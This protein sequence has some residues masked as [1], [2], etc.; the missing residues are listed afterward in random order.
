MR[1]TLILSLITLVPLS[2][3]AQTI[4]SG[5]SG[6]QQIVWTA[7]DLTAKPSAFSYRTTANKGFEAYQK[8]IQDAGLRGCS[9]EQ[10]VTLVSVVGSILSFREDRMTMCPGAAHPGNAYRFTSIDLSRQGDIGYMESGEDVPI[11]DAEKPGL[12][13]SLDS[14]FPADAI[15]RALS[16]DS[17]LKSQLSDRPASLKELGE[18][19]QGTE[20][21]VPNNPCTFTLPED[22][23]TRFAFHHLE[24]GQVAV[25]IFLEPLAGACHGAEAQLGILLPISQAM[26][27]PLN[28]AARGTE[29]FLVS[30]TKKPSARSK[31]VFRF[32]TNGGNR[33]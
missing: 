10:S 13:V 17:L 28:R 31:T 27:E 4:W 21:F 26:L 8:S 32:K 12:V 9:Y 19:M 2:S 30:T 23:L 24:R 7:S 11:V 29:G 14:L 25:R 20:L 33:P 5:T 22:Y 6:N 18:V 16:E 3:Q 15:I 1:R